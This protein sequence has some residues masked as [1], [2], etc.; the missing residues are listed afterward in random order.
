M[1][2][3]ARDLVLRDAGE[4]TTASSSAG[5]G[6]DIVINV[7]GVSLEKGA[8]ISA[9]SS[10]TG[11]AGSIRI[12]AKDKV[13]ILKASSV[14]NAEFSGGGRITINAGELLYLLK[15][16]ITS[17]VADGSGNGGDIIIDPVF[18]V[19]DESRILANAFAGAGGNIDISANFFFASPDSVLD[20]SS[21]LGTNG[22]IVIQSDVIQNNP[23][24][25]SLP[26]SFLDA[27]ALLHQRCAASA[28]TSTSSFVVSGRG[29]L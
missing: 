10:S 19:L 23:I 4:I 1:L 3:H 16:G 15:S 18:V 14:T 17:S 22:R 12:T 28:S 6:G 2:I 9:E 26:A 5:D 27:S 20:A 8:S 24:L 29:G 7:N 11:N 13:N 21:R 25:S